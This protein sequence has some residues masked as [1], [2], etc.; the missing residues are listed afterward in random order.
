MH[1]AVHQVVDTCRRIYRFLIGGCRFQV[2]GKKGIRIFLA[3]QVFLVSLKFY[4]AGIQRV[5]ARAYIQ[6]PRVLEV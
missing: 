3:G 1:G 5:T 4:L 2:F 6:R